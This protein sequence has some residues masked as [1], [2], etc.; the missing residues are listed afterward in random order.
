[1]LWDYFRN[2]GHGLLDHVNNYYTCSLGSLK[3]GGREG[4]P[5]WPYVEKTLHINYPGNEFDLL[6]ISWICSE[7]SKHL[8]A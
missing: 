4:S 1:M 3:G 2:H 5:S 8:L 7:R 6:I